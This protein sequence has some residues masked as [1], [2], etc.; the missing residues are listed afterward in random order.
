MAFTI[1]DNDESTAEHQSRLMQTDIDALSAAFNNT[2]V[3]SGCAV[4]AQGTPDMTVAV[5]AGNAVVNDTYVTVAGGNVTV[6]AADANPRI[7]LIRADNTGTKGI[8]TGTAAAN[9]KAPA[10]PANNVLLAMVYVP[11]SAT[12]ITSDLITDKRVISV[13]H[14]TS[15]TIS[16]WSGATGLVDSVISESGT[17]VTLTGNLALTSTT[18]DTMFANQHAVDRQLVT[19]ATNEKEIHGWIRVGTRLFAAQR[20]G[21]KFLRFNDLE[22]L[23]DYDAITLSGDWEDVIYVPSKDL[24]YVLSNG[25]GSSSVWVKSI[26]PDN[27][28]TTANVI[29]DDRSGDTGTPNWLNAQSI[30]CDGTYFYVAVWVRWA[31]F[32][33]HAIVYQYRVSDYGYQAQFAI[34]GMTSTQPNPHAIRWDG[35]KLYVTGADAPPWIARITPGTMALEELAEAP[36]VTGDTLT[37]FTD[38]MG[39]TA[40]YIFLASEAITTT[41]KLCRFHKMNLAAGC[42]YI[43]I[44]HS[45]LRAVA[46]HYDGDYVWCGFATDSHLVRVSPDSLEVAHFHIEGMNGMNEIVS[47]AQR[48]FCTTWTDNPSKVV[49]ISKP[50]M[51]AGT[52]GRREQPTIDSLAVFAAL[53]NQ[54]NS[55]TLASVTASILSQSGT[56]LVL[57]GNSIA[58]AVA[59]KLN[60]AMLAIASQAIGDLLY[61]NGTTTFARLADVA[62]GSYLRSGGVNTAPLW[63]TLTLPNAATTGDILIATAANAIGVV[64][65]VAIGSYLR[66]AGT[67]TAPIWSTLILPNAA[68]TGDL[69]TATSANTIGV[70]ADVAVGAYLRSGGVG[71]IPLWS[72]LILPNA[73]TTGDILAATSANTVGVI[74]AGAAGTVLTGNGA[75]AASTFQTLANTVLAIPGTNL[76]A[77]GVQTSAF[78]AGGT[79]T[80]G[81]LVILNS[82]SQW[83]QT[84]ANASSTYAGLL[85]VSLE[86]KTVGQAML[87]ALPGSIVRNTAWAWTPGATLYISETAATITATQPTTTDAVIR[88]VGYAVDA[89]DIYFI[90]S[91]SWIT[92]T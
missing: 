82:S 50:I 34:T 8:T 69:L 22:D 15:G 63:S 10:L 89:D 1:L 28:A 81:D 33:Y 43:D 55:E 44:G 18:G 60:A 32:T 13:R 59:G 27:L 47:D 75:G 24:L 19:L 77:S 86:S 87:V 74:T 36:G 29:L 66:S 71:T 73:A 72:T 85:A 46:V 9:P 80:A 16:K 48:L 41:R 4:T 53:Y 20:S 25:G 17:L 35:T 12:E 76:T 57:G 40:D 62:V 70:I 52:S 14:G 31:N 58:G 2:Y 7:D 78:Q 61:A 56:A 5:A 90:P 37:A 26:D 11:G 38:D 84:D 88:V 91:G 68:T 39:I 42:E 30:T 3:T 64:A 79:I 67:G 49:R 45:D 21:D 83:V 92:H 54:S 6:T 51:L 65:A 23:S